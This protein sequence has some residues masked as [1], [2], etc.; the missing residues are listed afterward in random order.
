MG[1][2]TGLETHSKRS[3]NSLQRGR[4]HLS[5]LVR[6]SSLRTAREWHGGKC[7]KFVTLKVDLPTSFCAFYHRGVIEPH[8]RHFPTMPTVAML[9]V[10]N[11]VGCGF[12]LSLPSVR[13]TGP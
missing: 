13:F 12:V 10:M 3:S 11:V 7:P 4:G 5:R 1:W 8:D 9:I 6:W 2:E